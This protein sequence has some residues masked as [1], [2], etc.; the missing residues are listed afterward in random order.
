MAIL[1]GRAS[2]CQVRL[3]RD[4]YGF[5]PF[6]SYWCLAIHPKGWTRSAGHTYGMVRIGIQSCKSQPIGKAEVG[7]ASEVKVSGPAAEVGKRGLS[8]AGFLG[9]FHLLG[10]TKDKFLGDTRR[11]QNVDKRKD[12]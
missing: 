11:K 4:E 12:E 3:L 2:I 10:A 5:A 1:W 7:T 8:G 9:L 6:P